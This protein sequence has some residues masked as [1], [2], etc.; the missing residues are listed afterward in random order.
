MKVRLPGNTSNNVKLQ[1]AILV[2]GFRNNLL[3]VSRMTDNNYTVIFR[4]ESAT[5]ERPDGSI[6]MIAR[7]QGKL[8]LVDSDDQE[9][10]FNSKEYTSKRIQKW[11]NRFGHLNFNDLKKLKTNDMVSGIDFNPNETQINCEICHMGK[12]SQT[13]YEKSTNRA[14]ERLALVHSDICGPMRTTSI[15]GSRYFATFIDDYTRYTEVI[16]LKNRSEIL[17]AFRK[18][19]LRVKRECGHGI[20]V[21]R[22]DNA[23][24]YTSKEFSKLLESEGIRHELTVPHTATKWRSRESQPHVGRNGEMHVITFRNAHESLGG[25]NKHRKLHTKQMPNQSTR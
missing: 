3:S 4:K 19:M 13:P 22:T 10:A 1:D 11:H 8:Y 12:I 15:G 25:S 18:Y 24:E 7:R 21:L 20:K 6:A 5:V 16:M 9:K 2:P 14:K 17:P 23:K